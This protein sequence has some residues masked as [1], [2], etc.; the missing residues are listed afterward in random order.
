ML[1][2][3]E[4]NLA[5]ELDLHAGIGR[6][7]GNEFVGRGGH[8]HTANEFDNAGIMR[9]SSGNGKQLGASQWSDR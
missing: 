9:R 4:V 8:G 6:A 7:I 1:V 2:G 5:A 3:A